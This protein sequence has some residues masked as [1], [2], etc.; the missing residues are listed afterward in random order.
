[1]TRY[2]TDLNLNTLV[3]YHSPGVMGS[4]ADKVGLTWVL[5]KVTNVMHL[6]LGLLSWTGLPL[7]IC[8]I[9]LTILVRGIMFPVSRKAAMTNIRMQELQP[10]IKKLKEKHKDD[11]QALNVAIWGVAAQVGHQPA[12]HLLADGAA[13]ACLH[14]V[15]YCT[16]QGEY[17]FPGGG[18]L[19]DVDS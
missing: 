6:V 12:E 15:L 13:N 8:I 14:G 17:L 1:M 3:D 19:A 4:T 16:L 5:I 7:G 9:V 18:V 10:E 11:P 2:T